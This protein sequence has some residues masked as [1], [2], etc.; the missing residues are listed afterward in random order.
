MDATD[1]Y[2][3][4]S[5]GQV[6]F[7]A[8]THFRNRDLPGET[9]RRNRFLVLMGRIP[10]N[11]AVLLL[12]DIFDFYFEYRSTVPK[13]YFDIFHALHQC[14]RRGVQLHFLGG[15]HDCWT[16][17]F[18]PNELGITVHQEKI[19]IA[20]QGRKILC[21][22]GDLAMKGDVGYKVLRAF[23]RNRVV[24]AAARVLH[25]E[26]LGAIASSVSKQS[27][28]FRTGPHHEPIARKLGATAHKRFF[29]EGNDVFVMGHVHHPLHINEDGKEFL[30]L[31]GWIEH[32]TYGKLVNGRLELE[33]FKE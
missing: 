3:P 2:L 8:D 28:S 6:F 5:A 29:S 24:V 10:S 7:I 19:R 13:R 25:P 27:K 22:H 26:L 33:A 31:G 21:A 16:R 17:D 4:I 18:F 20:C 23:L 11:A 30:I 9:E 12:G 32:Y 15:N 14:S 1:A